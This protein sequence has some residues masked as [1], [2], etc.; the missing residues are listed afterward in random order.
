MEKRYCHYEVIRNYRKE[1]V[2][3][4][5][6]HWDRGCSCNIHSDGKTCQYNKVAENK[7]Q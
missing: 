7:Y 4:F 2:Y 1:N 5:I 6:C 3:L